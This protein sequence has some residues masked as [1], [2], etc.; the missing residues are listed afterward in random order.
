MKSIL[1]KYFGSVYDVFEC[2]LYDS[3]SSENSK[4]LR[5]P[6]ALELWMEK[7]INEWVNDMRK[8]T[9]KC[10]PKFEFFHEE[11]KWVALNKFILSFLNETNKMDLKS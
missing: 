6:S 11:N 10:F 7:W 2:K 3:S 9:Y 5:A 1:G 4:P 8:E